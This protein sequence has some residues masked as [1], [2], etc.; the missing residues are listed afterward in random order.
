V[1]KAIFF[2]LLANFLLSNAGYVHGEE[3]EKIEISHGMY[4]KA[5]NA[6]YG[7]PVLSEK[8]ESKFWPIPQTKALYRIG[9]SD[10]MILH[11]FSR[12]VKKIT[13]LN[14]LDLEEATAVFEEEAG[15]QKPAYLMAQMKILDE[16]VF[17]EYAKKASEIVKEYGGEYLIRSKKIEPLEGGWD[18]ERVVVIRFDTL[19]DLKAWLRSPEYE[20]I[21]P[22]REKSASSKAIMIKG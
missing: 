5:V 17:S 21:K 4:E 8:I 12:R 14:G 19:G 6:K 20:A 1:K 13:I 22:L 2:F 9:E 10:Y 16:E 18:P 15:Q 3:Y 7:E 11:F